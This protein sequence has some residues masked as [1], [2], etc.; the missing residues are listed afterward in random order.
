MKPLSRELRLAVAFPA[1]SAFAPG[2]VADGVGVYSLFKTRLSTAQPTIG[3]RAHPRKSFFALPRT[4]WEFVHQQQSNGDKL[5][6]VIDRL[7][8]V[9]APY[10]FSHRIEC[11]RVAV[12]TQPTIAGE[13]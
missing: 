10:L 7:A 11:S 5:C 6:P 12:L 13:R 1:M 4:S 3:F 2:G 9:S 8:E